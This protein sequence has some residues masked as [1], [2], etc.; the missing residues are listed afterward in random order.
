[1]VKIKTLV[2]IPAY[3]EEESIRK[4]IEEIKAN[5]SNVDIVVINDGSKDNTVKEASKTTA[6]VID[7]PHNL[8]IGGA[9]Q[10]GYLYAYKNDYDYAVQIDGDGQHD[11]KYIQDMLEIMEKEKV[12]M[13]IGSRFVEKTGY[14]QTFMRA[15]GNKILVFLIKLFTGKKIFDTT[16]GYRM[17]NRK[18]ITMF[19]NSYPYDYPEPD[20][21]MQLL[22]K[23]CNIKEI[24]VEMRKRETGKSFASPLKSVQY[25]VKVSL[26]LCIAKLRK[27]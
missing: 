8:G 2:I 7:L 13:I 21:N 20:T 26:A 14:E 15:L 22:L 27:N 18:I 12:D 9:V 4:V 6:T 10:T 11:S 16:S 23:G 25:M 24:P 5:N 3:N 1:M 17:V 19:A